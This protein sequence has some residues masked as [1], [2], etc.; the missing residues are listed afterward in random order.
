MELMATIARTLFLFDFRL[1]GD[2]G[3]GKPGRG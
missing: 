2:L 3:E 1:A